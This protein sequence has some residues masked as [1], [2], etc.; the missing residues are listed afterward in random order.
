MSQIK[1]SA[2]EPDADGFRRVLQSGAPMAPDTRQLLR[3]AAQLGPRD[4]IAL[5]H[6]IKRAGEVCDTEGEDVALAMLDQIEAI[7]QGRKAN[8]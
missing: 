8:A 6:I 1:I 3:M 7:L 4:R 2:R 5:G